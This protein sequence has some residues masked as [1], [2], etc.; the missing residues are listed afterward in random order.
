MELCDGR[1]VP[2]TCAELGW[3][4]GTLGCAST[5]D[6]WDTSRCTTCAP[7]AT[8]RPLAAR[9]AEAPGDALVLAGRGAELGVAWIS[10][11]CANVYFA[12]A[13]SG[14]ALAAPPVLVTAAG[15]GGNA[16]LALAATSRGWLLAVTRVAD[17]ALYAISA[18]GTPMPAFALAGATSPTLTPGAPGEPALLAV[19][20]RTMHGQLETVEALAALVGEDGTLASPARRFVVSRASPNVAH[21]SVAARV[22]D[23]FLLVRTERVPAS[24][25]GGAVIARVAQDGTIAERHALITPAMQLASLRATDAGAELLLVSGDA[26]RVTLS[27][28]G[29]PTGPPR[30]LGPHET[31]AVRAIGPNGYAFVVATQAPASSGALVSL[32]S[33]DGARRRAFLDPTATTVAVGTLGDAPV[34]G[35]LHPGTG[36]ALGATLWL[37]RPAR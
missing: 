22:G 24:S 4:G 19:E 6:R 34:V 17:V 26:Q 15:G 27:P 12:R 1:D 13:R 28:G 35:W 20:R 32:A 11:T 30:A 21:P 9:G 36:A 31:L 10:A 5:C 2:A 37:A 23:G 16:R 29:E 14:L 18:N 7:G 8:C 33:P 3:A 25:A